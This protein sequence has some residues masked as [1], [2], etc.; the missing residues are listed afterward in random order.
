MPEETLR[1]TVDKFTF[2]IPKGLSYSDAGVWVKPEGRR[3]RLGL[4]DF[5][6]QRSGDVAFVRIKPVGTVLEA[7][8]DFAAIETVKVNISFPTPLSGTIVEINAS[9]E[10]AAERINQDPY[11]SGWLAVIDPAGGET[12]HEQRL[13]AE[14]YAAL[15][16]EQAEAEMKG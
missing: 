6:Q 9:L 12:A 8:E 5:A 3:V 4:S 16:K 10:E 11:G 1:V 13:D 15:V 2:L 14:A 7:G